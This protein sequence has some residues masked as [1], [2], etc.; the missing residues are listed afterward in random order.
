MVGTFVK[1]WGVSEEAATFVVEV[2]IS[3]VDVTYDTFRLMRELAT[4]ATEDERRH[5]VEI[6]FAISAAD[7]DMS[8]EEVEEIRVISR[9]LNLTHKDFIDAKLK[10][11][12]SA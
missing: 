3:A 12:E 9:G 6:L 10:I 2:A 1:I 7:G 4:S 8:I 5:V 11:L